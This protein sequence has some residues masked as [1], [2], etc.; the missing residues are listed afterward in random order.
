MKLR[1][2]RVRCVLLSAVSLF[3]LHADAA[4]ANDGKKASSPPAQAAP[5]DAAKKKE[6]EMGKVEGIEQKRGDGYFGV[7]LVG[8]NF[9][10][11]F[12]DAKRRVVP[13]PVN[14]VALR[15]PVNY[16]P[17][18]ERTVLN[19]SGDGKSLTSSKVVKPPH[20]FKLFITLLADGADEAGAG[21][22]TYTIDFRT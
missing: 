11:T 9:K 3:A 6:A 14:R 12:Y 17:A 1:A 13:A 2:L 21:T 19:I 20:L 4:T 16:R 7:E 10:I 18:D 8:G 22:E 5:A 15:W